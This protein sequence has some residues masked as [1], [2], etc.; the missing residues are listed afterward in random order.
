MQLNNEKPVS[1][2]V[3]A[4]NL[5]CEFLCSRPPPTLTS[6]V[7]ASTEERIDRRSC[8]SLR[9]L[10]RKVVNTLKVLGVGVRE[11]GIC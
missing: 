11:S 8:F 5:V 6:G 7:I 10:Q 2:F 9:A 4:T 1:E 3:K